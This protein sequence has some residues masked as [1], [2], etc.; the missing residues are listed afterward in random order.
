MIL[1]HLCELKEGGGERKREREKVGG[2]SEESGNVTTSK[3][4]QDMN[5]T[6]PPAS[7]VFPAWGVVAN[8]CVEHVIC[9]WATPRCTMQPS[10]HQ[11]LLLAGQQASALKFGRNILSNKCK[12]FLQRKKAADK[13]CS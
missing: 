2:D 5:K 6:F 13:M 1:I 12:T 9:C 10:K 4:E 8:V 11:L 7:T 3:D